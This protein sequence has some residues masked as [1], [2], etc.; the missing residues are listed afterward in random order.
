MTRMLGAPREM[1]PARISFALLLGLLASLGGPAGV[2]RADAGTHTLRLEG[3]LAL[4]LTE[5]QAT[6]FGLGGGFTLGYELRP[7]AWLGVEARLSGFWLPS[8]TSAPTVDGFGTSYGAGL[9]V[10]AHPLATLGVGDL[11]VGVGGAAV[12]TGD[13]VRPGVE[14]GFG[15]EFGLAWWLRAGP[16]VRYH[17]V[18]QTATGGT[19]AGVLFV[20]V[21]LAF[22][23]VEPPRDDD[24][25]GLFDAADRCP[26]A[27]E[28]RDGFEDSDGCP[29]ADN[30]GDGVLD[31]SDRCADALED[32]DGFADDDGCPD[33]DN[34]QDSILDAVDQCRD[35]AEDR[36]QFQD[37]DG[38]ADPDNDADRVL[39]A[40]DRCL[41]EPETRNGFE[42][43][44]GCPDE[45]PRTA[46]EQHLD[47][48][49]ERI[50]FRQNRAYLAGGS[51]RALRAVIALLNAHPEIT[52]L[53]VEA[54]ASRE[55]DAAQNMELSERR[56]QTVVDALAAGGIARSRLAVHAFGDQQ[57]EHL[58]D[59]ETDYALN[60]RAV[61]VAERAAAP[62]P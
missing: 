43:D 35:V 26:A 19:D 42:D 25:D 53:T 41:N 14:A 2:A 49:G 44:D 22:F 20:G 58:G 37:D 34:D 51:R 1:L 16:F 54:H 31:P 46:E 62:A 12:L 56:A 55:G 11:W 9:G 36:D 4:P 7:L 39:D 8:S 33:P 30:D 47:R 52:L 23:G 6:R 17:H 50:L 5:P 40:Q 27:P 3:G 29:D 18:F 24:H 32:R 13:L 10:R 28:D 45:A 38:C 61:F 57:P 21:S 60:R 48:L 59:T 15:Y